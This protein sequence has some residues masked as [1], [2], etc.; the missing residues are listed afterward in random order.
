[1]SILHLNNDNE[2]I[3]GT[4]TKS[5]KSYIG[6]IQKNIIY[7]SK[8]KDKDYISIIR[9]PKQF[10]SAGTIF[11]LYL[12]NEEQNNDSINSTNNNES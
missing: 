8:I 9:D 10:I 5:R 7:W 2:N 1:M 6:K 3:I 12:V 11:A 4:T